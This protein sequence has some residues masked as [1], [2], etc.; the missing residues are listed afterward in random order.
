MS[1]EVKNIYKTF[2]SKKTNQLSVLENINL[3][4][5]DGEL[6]CK[7]PTKISYLELC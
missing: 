3:T 7:T 6:I 4:I 2:K 1:I 5:N